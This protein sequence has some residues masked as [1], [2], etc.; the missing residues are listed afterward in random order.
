MQKLDG[1]NVDTALFCGTTSNN[2]IAL[3]K[4]YRDMV[5]TNCVPRLGFSPPA[6]SKEDTVLPWPQPAK[7]PSCSVMANLRQ[8][9]HANARPVQHVRSPADGCAI[10]S[11]SILMTQHPHPHLPGLQCG[12][13]G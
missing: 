7:E 11:R 1:T 4:A 2:L 6:L 5:D 3:Y 8:H 13:G 12:Y 9:S 10:S